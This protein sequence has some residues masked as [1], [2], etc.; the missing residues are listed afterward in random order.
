MS[1]NLYVVVFKENVLIL[2][3]LQDLLSMCIRDCVGGFPTTHSS[4]TQNHLWYEDLM[5][6]WLMYYEGV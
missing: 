6:K 1:Y 3:N 5:F 2:D 4:E